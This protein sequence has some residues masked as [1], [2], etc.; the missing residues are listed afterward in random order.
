MAGIATRWGVLVGL[1]LVLVGQLVP[2]E[3]GLAIACGLSCLAWS[4]ALRR[5]AHSRFS[6]SAAALGIVGRAFLGV[7]RAI[8]E[9]APAL[10]CPRS[11]SVR[12]EPFARGAANPRDAGRRAAALLAI[13]LAPDHYALRWA[14]R[15][16][17]LE[18]HHL[19]MR[20]PG[21]PT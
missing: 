2:D 4:L 8:A 13:S 6:C 12:R 7:P 19:S 10:L 14:R 21:R 1:Y 5:I 18:I 15:G 11:G 17:A 3:V 16:N 20:P 9:V